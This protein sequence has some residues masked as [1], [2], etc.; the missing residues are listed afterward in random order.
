[1]RVLLPLVLLST[2]AWAESDKQA[3]RRVV[4]KHIPTIA[5]CF[6]THGYHSTRVVVDFEVGKTGRVTSAAA[7]GQGDKALQDCIVGVF[8]RMTFPPS[9]EA[10][11]VTYPVQICFAGA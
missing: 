9:K 4:K 6:E 7:R 8:K 5:M 11:K 3:I 1:M 2:L 10:I